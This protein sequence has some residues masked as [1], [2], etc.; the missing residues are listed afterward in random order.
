LSTDNKGSALTVDEPFA[1]RD[2]YTRHFQPVFSP[3]N[4][5]W[6]KLQSIEK[7]TNFFRFLRVTVLENFGASQVSSTT[8]KHA[9]LRNTH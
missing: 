8:A 5:S 6:P 2:S 3:S 4:Y 7:V 1:Y 9:V